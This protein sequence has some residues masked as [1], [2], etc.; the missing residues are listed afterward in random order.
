LNIAD[1]NT[2]DVDVVNDGR[3]TYIG[4]QAGD[5]SIGGR[6]TIIGHRAGWGA[7]N[8]NY[9]TVFGF[10]AGLKASSANKATILGYRAGADVSGGAGLDRATLV[11]HDA[12][13]WAKSCAD[14]VFIGHEAGSRSTNTVNSI[15]IGNNVQ[16][17]HSTNVA[18]FGGT[19]ISKTVLRGT[20]FLENA[21]SPIVTGSTVVLWNSNA[22][23]YAVSATATNKLLP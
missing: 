3:G 15:L 18:I 16:S 10:G 4:Y 22:T 7:T 11:G 23:L 6:T 12:G 8:V 9:S 21:S 5:G 2:L 13:R 20:V 14:S 1:A 17:D 19:N